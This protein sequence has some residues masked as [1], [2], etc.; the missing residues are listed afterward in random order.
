MN[1]FIDRALVVLRSAVTWLTLLATVLGIVAVNL[2]PFTGDNPEVA[3]L[4][5][6]I[7]VVVAVIAVIVKMISMVTP[8]L[9]SARGL[10]PVPES[11]PVTSRERHLQRELD[12]QRSLIP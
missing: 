8:V 11:L 6:F 10:L 7:A 1:Q 4:V 3:Q 12:Y 2:Q 5:A 9:E